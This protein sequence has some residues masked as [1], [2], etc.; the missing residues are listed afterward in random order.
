MLFVLPVQYTGEILRAS[1]TALFAFPLCSDVG[2]QS[3]CEMCQTRSLYPAR[4]LTE[5]RISYMGQTWFSG[6]G[7]PKVLGSVPVLAPLDPGGKWALSGSLF[8]DLTP[9]ESES[10]PQKKRGWRKVGDLSNAPTFV[11]RVP[12]LSRRERR[13]L[14]PDPGQN[15]RES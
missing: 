4:G 9:Q 8:R 6:G 7:S 2:S 12:F 15:A 10:R 14:V 11:Q 5:Y 1:R 3:K 13:V